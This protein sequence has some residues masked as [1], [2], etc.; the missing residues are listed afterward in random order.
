MAEGLRL[1]LQNRECELTV[2]SGMSA[3]M[4]NPRGLC[5]RSATFLKSLSR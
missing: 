5:Y 4:V 3:G 1:G 2:A